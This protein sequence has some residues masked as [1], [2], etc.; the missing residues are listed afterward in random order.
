MRRAVIAI[1]IGSLW[2]FPGPISAQSAEPPNPDPWEGFNR[3]MQAFNDWADR[4]VLKPVAKGYVKV[5]PSP[6]RRGVGNVFDNLWTPLTIVNQLL[7]GKG[8]AS[9]NDTGRFLMNSTVGLAGLF[10]PATSVGLA[11]HDETFGQTF[12][13]WGIPSGPYLVLPFLGPSTVRNGVGRIGDVQFFAPRYIED[14]AWRIGVTALYFVD[15]RSRLLSAEELISGDR[16]LF[17]RDA[18]LQSDEF[19]MKDGDID[20]EDDAFLDDDWEDE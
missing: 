5:I 17:I 2:A 3:K 14:T 19:A 12:G 1:L 6:L 20:V 13:V 10:D 16:Y 8:G 4:W 7:Q 15:L 11:R 9:L 18:Y